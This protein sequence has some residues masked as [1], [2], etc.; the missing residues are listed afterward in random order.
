MTSKINKF[1][2]KYKQ[3]PALEQKKNIMS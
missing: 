1:T 3:K 2:N